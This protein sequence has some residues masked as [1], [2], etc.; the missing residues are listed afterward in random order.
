M[1]TNVPSPKSIKVIDKP[2]LVLNASQEIRAATRKV[3]F[4]G[5]DCEWGK[6][7]RVTQVLQITIFKK[8]KQEH[9]EKG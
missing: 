2:S 6:D 1:D 9:K 8:L 4:I 5:L 7:F 3:P